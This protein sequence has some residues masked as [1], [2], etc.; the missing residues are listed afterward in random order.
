MVKIC[1][2]TSW[3]VHLPLVRIL[4]SFVQFSKL[5]YKFWWF[6]QSKLKWAFI[7]ALTCPWKQQ[8]SKVNQICRINSDYS[9]MPLSDLL[10]EWK[11]PGCLNIVLIIYQIQVTLECLFYLTISEIKLDVLSGISSRFKGVSRNLLELRHYRFIENI[12]IVASN[13]NWTWNNS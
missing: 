13:W 6:Y 10:N 1:V 3:N 2:I 5:C 9:L 7:I 4:L 8:L 12:G 11:T